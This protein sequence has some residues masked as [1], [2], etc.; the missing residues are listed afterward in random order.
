THRS[1]CAA[2]ADV[3]PAVDDLE[4][5]VVFIGQ[6]QQNGLNGS[7]GGGIE[8]AA[9]LDDDAFGHVGSS[10]GAAAVRI[11]RVSD[12]S[13]VYGEV[14]AACH[15]CA[16]HFFVAAEGAEDSC[17]HAAKE[18]GIRAGAGKASHFFVVEEADQINAVAAL[19]FHQ[20]FQQ[21]A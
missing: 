3:V 21:G 2:A 6:T 10:G 14:N 12:V 20:S 4:R 9:C 5:N 15:G 17:Q 18:F 1:R 19:A 16:V 8:G 7:D 13:A 11:V